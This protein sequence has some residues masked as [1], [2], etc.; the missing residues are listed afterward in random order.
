M[1]YHTCPNCHQDR[2]CLA[3]CV[4]EPDLSDDAPCGCNSHQR[5]ATAFRQD[6]TPD[7]RVER[8]RGCYFLCSLC[9][10]RFDA[11]KRLG[12]AV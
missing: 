1:H 11:M 2:P 9:R 7:N 3:D 5:S 6:G 8:E 12:G 4:V 10:P